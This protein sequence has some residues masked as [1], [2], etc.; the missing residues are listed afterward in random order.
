VP[1]ISSF[2]D[3]L[4]QYRNDQQKM[5]HI[6][7]NFDALICE[8]ANKDTVSKL[9]IYCNDS[10]ALK[11]ENEDLLD[12]TKEL[13]EATNKKVVYLEELVKMQS[14]A[15]QKELYSAVRRAL[16]QLNQQS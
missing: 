15:V 5:Q 3:K 16:S 1:S 8:K 4:Q 13:V 12:N 6:I 2:E 14:K 7:R 10:F 9:E 11:S